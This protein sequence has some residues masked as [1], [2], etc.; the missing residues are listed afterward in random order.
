MHVSPGPLRWVTER[1]GLDGLGVLA[2]LTVW[3]IW[4]STYFAIRIGLET[5]EPFVLQAIRFSVAGTVLY[6]VARRR[7]APR[8]SGRQWASAALVGS[9]LLLGGLGLV[10][11][12][13]DR[14]VGSGLAATMIA[15]S[16]MW[17]ALWG[18]LLGRWPRQREWFG[19]VIGLASVVVLALGNDFGGSRTGL[20][21]LLVSPMSWTLGSALTSRLDLPPGLMASACE[22]L[23][24][25]VGFWSLAAATGEDVARPSRSSALAVGYLIVFGSVI[26]YSAYQHLLAHSRPAVAISYAYVNPVVAVL[27]GTLLL[28]EALTWG[29][30]VALPLV[31]VSVVL[32]TGAR[33]E[34]A[35]TEE[36]ARV[37]DRR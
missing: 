4:G 37:D 24:G 15:I 1:S 21:L 11:L 31:V 26:A 20:V 16:P 30:A 23:A 5:L 13:E 22:M 35:P 8:P 10:T 34:G 14:G 17:L 18:G 33:D 7:G 6:V 3:V 29:L 19:M 25:A 32:I 36:T 27:L 9:L 28:D 2:L 12:A